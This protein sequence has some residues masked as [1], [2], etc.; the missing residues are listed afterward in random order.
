MNTPSSLLRFELAKQ[1]VK[2]ISITNEVS[3]EAMLAESEH[4]KSVL[5]E[6]ERYIDNP[7]VPLEMMSDS[8][9]IEKSNAAMVALR[10]EL[11][12]ERVKRDVEDAASCL[13]LEDDSDDN[14]CDGQVSVYTP[15][16]STSDLLS[17]DED[18]DE[19]QDSKDS[20]VSNGEKTERNVGAERDGCK[21]QAQ[22]AAALSGRE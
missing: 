9:E 13:M 6:K 1:Q 22:S 14:S 17:D 11:T 18:V 8:R 5:A 3:L 21:Q 20:G 4:L 7:R 12:V 10:L 16:T 2:P 19:S 15:A